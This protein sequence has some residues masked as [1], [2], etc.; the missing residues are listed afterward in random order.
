LLSYYGRLN[1]TYDGK[2]LLTATMRRDGTSRF[3]PDTRWGTFP[4]IALGWTLTQ[5]NW[6]KDNKVLNN[7]KLRASYGVTGQQ[8][9][10]GNYNYLP[11]YTQSVD[12]AQA[13]INGQY[14]YTYRP[15]AYVS[16]L[17]WETT[18]SWD[19]GLDFGFLDNRLSGSFDYYTRK[20]KDL[21]AT[22]LQ[23]QEQTS[24]RIF[25]RMWVT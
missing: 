15:E 16:N 8:D 20:T 21:L 4:S 14:I 9:G 10:I 12:G 19:F 11:I 1:Y 6:L 23:Q 7:L 13:L 2:Y 17:K 3:S 24:Q 18:T 22:V 5:E 25:L